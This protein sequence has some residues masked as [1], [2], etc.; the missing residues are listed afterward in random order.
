M[1]IYNT[2]PSAVANAIEKALVAALA[3]VI[4]ASVI[5]VVPDIVDNKILYILIR[6][7]IMLTLTQ[8]RLLYK[9]RW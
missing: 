3:D 4:V 1:T 6:L 8:L 7:F 5:P 2:Y 9:K